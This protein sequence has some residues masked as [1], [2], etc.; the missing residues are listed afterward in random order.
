M[1]TFNHVPG[2]CNVLYMDA[3]VEFIKYRAKYPV[4]LYNGNTNV[5]GAGAGGQ[6]TRGRAVIDADFFNNYQPL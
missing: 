3:H 6:D 1:D 2:G 5:S 4:S